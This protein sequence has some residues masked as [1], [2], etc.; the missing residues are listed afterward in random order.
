MIFC[1]FIV[2]WN[3]SLFAQD[4]L[5]SSIQKVKSLINPSLFSFQNG[6]FEAQINYR[7]Q[8]NSASN[9]L[10]LRNLHATA[11]YAKDIFKV[12]KLS[13]GFSMLNDKGGQ[14]HF[15]RN[16]AYVHAAYAKKLTDYRSP[17]GEQFLS[18]GV[19]AGGGQYAV[20]WDRFWFG[21]Q[22]NRQF[23]IIDPN[24][25]SGEILI[26]QNESASTNIF[27]D[28]NAGLS[29]YAFFNE[30]FSAHAGIGLFHL[31]NPNVSFSEFA[32]EF[33]PTR[34]NVH[35]GLNL[36]FSE[37]LVFS[38]QATFIKQRKSQQMIV[39]AEFALQNED[40][41]AISPSLGIY[42]RGVNGLEGPGPD[43]LLFSVAFDYEQMRFG[44]VYDVTVSSLAAY[45]SGRGAWELN[46]NYL[47]KSEVSNFSRRRNTRFN[48]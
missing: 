20:K 29:W 30:N 21:N 28:I 34:F 42:L 37:L 9:G 32:E 24:M 25:D 12:D 48:F 2:V 8:G 1:F 18:I 33:L 31:N 22:Y 26:G 36:R 15:T 19:S 10:P 41:L 39:G 6:P 35:G 14:G 23:G 47:I 7:E 40:F 5:F 13:M 46:L 44:L 43:A 45:N 4:P 3:S 38:P 17:F 16:F 27:P 11:S